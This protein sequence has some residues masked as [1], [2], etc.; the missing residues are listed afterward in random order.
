MNIDKDKFRQRISEMLGVDISEVTPEAR[1]RLELGADSLD[2]VEILMDAEEIYGIA[3]SD[4]DAEAVTTVQEA[5]NLIEKNHIADT[6]K[7]VKEAHETE[8]N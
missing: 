2:C 7:M 4:E 1:F 3:I 5:I 6:G 8:N